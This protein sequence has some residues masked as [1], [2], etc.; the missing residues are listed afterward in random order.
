MREL[1]AR[2]LGRVEGRAAGAT[3]P[4]QPCSR[5]AALTRATSAVGV[6]VHVGEHG[7]AV[8]ARERAVGDPDGGDARV[9]DEQRPAD[10]ELADKLADAPDR[11]EA[12]NEPRRHL[13]A[14]DGIDLN[15]HDDE[16]IV[17]VMP[18]ADLSLEA[19]GDAVA[20]RSPAPASGSATA[21][22]AALRSLA[23]LTARFSDDEG[24]R[25][26]GLR[27]RL[28]ALADED[29]AAYAAFMRTRSDEERAA[30][31]VDVP[32][33]LAEAAAAVARLGARAR[34]P[35][36]GSSATPRPRSS[37]PG[38]PSRVGARLVELNLEG[39]DTT[40]APRGRARSRRARPSAVAG[41]RRASYSSARRRSNVSR[42][43][44]S[45]SRGNG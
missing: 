32:L 33:E 43:A 21:V 44:R 2:G 38:R 13:D 15:A 4:S 41:G 20:E 40:R 9:G 39:R 11:P 36:R 22:A 18:Y 37:S 42:N 35:T 12:V 26:G 24:R 25:R 8:Q 23:E 45:A 17:P 1:H 16:R 29:A 3:S 28:L 34:G 27:G 7:G 14:A 31:T 10:A 30:G 5:Y 19:F 6:R